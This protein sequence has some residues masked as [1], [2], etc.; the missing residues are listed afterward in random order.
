MSSSPCQCSGVDAVVAA[1]R[2]AGAC[3]AA[4]V[5]LEALDDADTALYDNWIARGANAGM[6]YL[7]RYSDIRRDPRLLLDGAQSMLVAAFA[8]APTPDRRSRLIADYALGDDYHTVLRERLRPVAQL[9]ESL[10]EG[11]ATRICVDT[12][13]LRERLWAARAGLGS[14]GLNN[15][16]I[17]PGIGSRVFLAEI[18]WTECIMHNF[19]GA[20]NQFPIPNSQSPIPFCINC[21]RCVDACPGGALDG[22]GGIDAGRCLSYLTIE[23][24]GDLPDTLSLRGRRI[25]GCDICQDVCPCNTPTPPEPVPEFAPRP[26]VASLTLDDIAAMDAATF[27]RTFARSA[28]KRAK[29]SGLLRNAKKA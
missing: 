18:L 22:K 11:S 12:A 28:V 3:A 1:A 27:S 19:P 20:E 6:D 7:A 4:F 26:A 29:L 8:Y 15:Q 24:R 25:Y 5:R 2:D 23:H 13:P 16:L 10:H 14:I 17:I 9:M 21:R